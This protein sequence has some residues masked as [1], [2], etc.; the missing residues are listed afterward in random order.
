[1]KGW[2]SLFGAEPIK[3]YAFYKQDIAHKTGGKSDTYL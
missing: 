2:A 3:I 1:M